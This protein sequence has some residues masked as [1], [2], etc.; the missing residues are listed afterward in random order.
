[1]RAEAVEAD[2]KQ[3]EE[4]RDADRALFLKA[5]K[6]AEAA[7]AEANTLSKSLLLHQDKLNAAEAEVARLREALKTIEYYE[8]KVWSD[9]SEAACRK[10]LEGK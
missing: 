3:C 9:A 8:R 4:E 2:H 7:E 10:A 1:M 5:G 6:R